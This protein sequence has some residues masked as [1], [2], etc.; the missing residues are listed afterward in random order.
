MT[1]LHYQAS[2]GA[3]TTVLIDRWVSYCLQPE[4]E[5]LR[6]FTHLQLALHR[7][8][9]FASQSNWRLAV[10]TLPDVPAKPFVVAAVVT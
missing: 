4:V 3:A 2:A 10:E 8:A 1:E 9:V 7:A 6:Q 5:G